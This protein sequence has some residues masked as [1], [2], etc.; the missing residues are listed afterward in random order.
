MAHFLI[1]IKRPGL[2]LIYKNIASEVYFQFLLLKVIK[3]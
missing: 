3:S 1:L 2:A